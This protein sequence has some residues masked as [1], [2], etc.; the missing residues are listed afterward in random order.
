MSTLKAGRPSRKDKAIASVQDQQEKM[1]RLN[2]NVSKSFYKQIK[3]KA[4]DE[5]SNV[6][7]IVKK[8]LIEYMSK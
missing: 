6:T 4:L 8:A 7:E 5:E 2:V 3:Q 1:I